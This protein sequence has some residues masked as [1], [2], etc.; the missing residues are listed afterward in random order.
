MLRHFKILHENVFDRKQRSKVLKEVWLLLFLGILAEPKI[1]Q[2]GL[3]CY[4]L[5]MLSFDFWKLMTTTLIE[6]ISFDG[7]LA[8]G[9]YFFCLIWLCPTIQTPKIS[10][11][12]GH[13]L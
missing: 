1:F 4:Y 5:L 13:E 11:H 2:K 6:R 3:F 8:H 7:K 12:T 9:I 10:Q